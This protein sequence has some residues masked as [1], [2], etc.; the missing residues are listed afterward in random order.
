MILI[1]YVRWLDDI[2][3]MLFTYSLNN[4]KKL[5]FGDHVKISYKMFHS[6]KNVMMQQIY[7]WRNLKMSGLSMNGKWHADVDEHASIVSLGKLDFKLLTR[8]HK[9]IK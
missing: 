4:R 9:I 6:Y 2:C 3:T 7:K 1:S 8:P 5:T